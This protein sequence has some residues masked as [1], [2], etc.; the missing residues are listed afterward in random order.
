MSE[1]EVLID[2]V[3]YCQ[4][5]NTKQS[6]AR[7]QRVTGN[8]PRFVKIGRSVRYRIGDVQDWLQ[9]RTVRS[10]SETLSGSQS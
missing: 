5:A 7:K 2:E 8:G 10:T 6:T 9:S 3:A 4:M 1:R